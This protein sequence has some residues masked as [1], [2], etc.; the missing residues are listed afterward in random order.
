L[1]SRQLLDFCHGAKYLFDASKLVEDD[2]G[3]A[4]AMAE[5]WRSTL[6]HRKDGPEVVIRALRYQR[7]ACASE[8]RSEELDTIIDLFAEH[9]REGRLAYKNAANDA[10]PIGTGNTEAAAKTIVNVRMKRAGARYTSHGGQTILNFRA[11]LLSGRFHATMGEII[12]R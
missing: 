10:Y 5:S 11:A 6:R 3:I 8:T 2:E 7:E 12:G 1:E 4:R 9:R